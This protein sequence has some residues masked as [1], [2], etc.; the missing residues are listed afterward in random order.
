MRWHKGNVTIK[1]LTITNTVMKYRHTKP[2]ACRCWT[3][4]R[5]RCSYTNIYDLDPSAI[6][7]VTTCQMLLSFEA[8]CSVHAINWP[9]TGCSCFSDTLCLCMCM[10]AIKKES[11]VSEET[12]TQTL[13]YHWGVERT[14]NWGIRTEVSITH[15]EVRWWEQEGQLEHSFGSLWIMTQNANYS[16]Q[17]N[18]MSPRHV[19][20][21]R[22][23][24]TSCADESDIE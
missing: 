18:A 3:V 22:P 6:W 2:L 8:Y 7:S 23:G 13:F 11:V 1:K 19:R 24:C 16:W 21:D 15:V 9:S 17:I 4:L 20:K 5:F 12:V 10:R 14:V